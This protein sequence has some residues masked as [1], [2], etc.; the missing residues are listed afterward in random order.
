MTVKQILLVDDDSITNMINT[1]LITRDF[2]CRVTAYTNAQ[3]TLTYLRGLAEDTPDDMPEVIFL[4]VNMPVMDGW[5]FLEEFQRFPERSLDKCS[6]IM[7]TSSIDYD[8]I[9]KSKKYSVVKDFVSKP[10]TREKIRE[11]IGS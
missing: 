2:D 4:D 8:D 7:L 11:L 1:K 10:L 6:V 9:E 3:E 5:E